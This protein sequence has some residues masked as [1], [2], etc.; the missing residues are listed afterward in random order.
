MLRL[1]SAAAIAVLLPLTANAFE[2]VADRNQ[3]VA[4]I[5]DKA[6]K[7]F[8]ITL[9]VTQSGD[10]AGRAFGQKVTGNWQWNDGYFCRD[11]YYGGESLGPNC[12]TVEVRGSTIRFTAD[13]G[14][15]QYADLRLE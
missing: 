2:R 12:Q 7:R 1:A 9:T 10:I 8:G 13:R 15:G 14:T 4:L 6:L 3:F 5:S 11:L